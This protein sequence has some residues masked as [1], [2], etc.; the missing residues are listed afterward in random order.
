MRAALVMLALVATGFD[1]A[2]HQ[3]STQDALTCTNCHAITK[4]GAL[5]KK[6][7]HAQCF[8]KCHGTSPT[9]PAK[10]KKLAVAPL[11]TT[12][13][14]QQ[15]LAGGEKK[16][17]L[18]MPP[19]RADFAL[20]TGHKR[21]AQVACEKCHTPSKPAP[22]TRC[23]GCHDG[24][25][26]KGPPMSL[27]TGCHQTADPTLVETGG[28]IPVRSAFSHAKHATR[29]TAAK[30]TTCHATDT[31]AL[32][33][34]HPT[35][36]Q[37]ATAGCHDGK[38]A[39][40]TT[41]SCTK[42]HQDVPPIRV[43][44]ERPDARFSHGFHL[45]Y[46]AF[47]PCTSCHTLMKS[48]EVG[49]AGHDACAPCHEDDFALRVPKTCGACHDATEPWRKLIPDR[50][51]LPTTDFG[52]S[53]DHTKHAPT[54]TSCHTLTTTGAQLRPPRGHS[55]CTGKACHATSGGPSPTLATCDGCHELGIAARRQ[56]QRLAAAWSVRRQFVHA[57]HP[58]ACTS[59]HLDMSGRDLLSIV[60]PP[61]PTCVPCHDGQ[62][63]FKITGTGCV[64]CHPPE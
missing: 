19:P 32:V 42:C 53:L 24:G 54:C 1:H 9:L 56:A 23:S 59:C 17:F 50:P 45:P 8:G 18:V 62:T 61:K 34:P 4:T 48:G 14:T 22:H 6:P 51:S 15:A 55:A 20:Q 30:C 49:V 36:A 41:Q 21:H 28:S 44:L 37:C 26:K 60:T 46:V 10:G 40:S 12:C 47:L 39:F 64:R 35:T 27:C 57:S 13:H 25:A 31:D 58:Q 38:T 2:K 63:S 29:G 7:G 5:A 43:R 33:L 52:A 11:C 16:A 3:T